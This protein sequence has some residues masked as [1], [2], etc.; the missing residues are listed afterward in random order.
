MVE[1]AL[2]CKEVVAQDANVD[3][4]LLAAEAIKAADVFMATM[5]KAV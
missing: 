1:Q 3:Y 2:F 4:K 5:D